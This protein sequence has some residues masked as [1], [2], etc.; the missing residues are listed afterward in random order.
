MATQ[1]LTALFDTRAEADRAVERLVS[2]YHLDRSAVTT[3]AQDASEAAYTPEQRRYED[4]GFWGSLKDLFLPEEDR[5]AYAEGVRRGGVLV[6]VRAEDAQAE[7]IMDLLE[8]NGAADVDLKEQEWRREGWVRTSSETVAPAGY[9]AETTGTLAGAPDGTPGNPPGTMLSRGVDQVAG[10][11]VSGA[12]PE[13]ERLGVAGTTATGTAA[14]ELQATGEERI[15]IVEEQLRVGKRAVQGGRVR[16]RSY[17]VE[18][19]V[20]EQVSLHS[21]TVQVERRNVDLPLSAADEAAFRERTI[22]ATETSEE[23]VIA[24]D[25]RV[26]EELVI[27]KTGADRTQTVNDT[28]RRTEV[29]VEDTRGKV[30]ETGTTVTDTTTA[31]PVTPRR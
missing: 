29:E 10:T 14:T 16:V 23:A 19:P 5:Y 4:R 1:V 8:A 17:V 9:R 20:T 31:T 11:N 30:V 26:R 12:H 7:Q 22:E 24:K 3:V 21:E 15:P 2:E 25:A 13:N 27:R 6:S 18:T 28:V